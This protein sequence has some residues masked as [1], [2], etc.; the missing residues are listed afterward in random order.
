MAE[1]IKKVEE[2]KNNDN[3]NSSSASDSD[4]DQNLI[5][6]VRNIHLLIY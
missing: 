5:L 6:K 3:Y 1:Q 4:S 2:N